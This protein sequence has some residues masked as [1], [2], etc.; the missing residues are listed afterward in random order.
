MNEEL[1]NVRVFTL[2]EARGLLPKLRKLLGRLSAEREVLISM[3]DEVKRAREKSEFG[4]GTPVGS[5]YL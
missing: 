5:S 4:G 1:N 2:G 3:R